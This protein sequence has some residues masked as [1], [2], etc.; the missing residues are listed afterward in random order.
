[1]RRKQV[2]D[3]AIAYSYALSLTQSGRMQ[4]TYGSTRVCEV[5][6]FHRKALVSRKSLAGFLNDGGEVNSEALF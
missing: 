4:K 1:M 5:E 3:I 6:F 2:K